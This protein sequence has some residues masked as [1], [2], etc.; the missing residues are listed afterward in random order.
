MR[1][2]AVFDL[3]QLTRDLS[4]G[5]LY[6]LG[7]VLILEPGNLMRWVP[8]DGAAWSHEILRLLG[9]GLLGAAATP[10]ILALTRRLP[11]EGPSVARRGLVHLGFGAATTL[12]LIVASCLLGRLLPHA[13]HRPMGREI[14]EELTANG[15]LVAAWIG[16]LTA[17]AH[18]AR[19]RRREAAATDLAVRQRGR[20][21]RLD[22]SQVAWIETQGNYLALHA[23]TGVSLLRRTAKSLEPELDP[24]RFVRVHRR[25]IVA[26]EAVQSVTPLAA[27]DAVLCLKTGETLRV[28]RSCRARLHQAL[29]LG[30]V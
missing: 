1:Q 27:G 19:H 26:L 2:T 8:P 25:A 22:L 17:L 7:L 24:S 20:F 4:F 9:A 13:G 14:V 16:G 5:F 30:G 11:I 12:A 23:A 10:A 15:P 29:G 6:W 18:A 21:T 28:S 3:R